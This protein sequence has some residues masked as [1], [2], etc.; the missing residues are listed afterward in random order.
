[1]TGTLSLGFFNVAMDRWRMQ[2]FQPGR[3]ARISPM[4]VV[5]TPIY[6]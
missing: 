5:A 4:L 2:K 1:M 3:L 6:K